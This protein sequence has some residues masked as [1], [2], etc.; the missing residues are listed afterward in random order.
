MQNEKETGRIFSGET[1]WRRLPLLYYAES[2]CREKGYDTLLMHYSEYRDK[3]DMI[4]IEENIRQT[5]SYVRGRIKEKDLALYDEILFVSKSLG[6]VSA[7]WLADALEKEK[8]VKPGT[9]R[10]IFMTPLEQTFPYMRKENCIVIS[11]E[12]DHYLERKKLKK[13][14]K[15]HEVLW[16][17]FP[18]VG[19]SMEHEKIKDTLKTMKKI[20]K[21]VENYV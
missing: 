7:G 6:T 21:I 12:L 1:L 2:I 17:C 9:I 3:K 13:F 20:M 16:Y 11:G 8:R 15:K 5:L 19:H 10:H 4:T 18:D 14:C